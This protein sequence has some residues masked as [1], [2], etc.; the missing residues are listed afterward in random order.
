[1][2]P[3]AEGQPPLHREC[4]WGDLSASRMPLSGLVSCRSGSPCGRRSPTRAGCWPPVCSC[5][6]CPPCGSRWWRWASCSPSAD[7]RRGT[8]RRTDAQSPGAAGP[9]EHGVRVAGRPACATA[10]AA[11]IHA[12]LAPRARG[13]CSRHCRALRTRSRHRPTRMSVHAPLQMAQAHCPP[14]GPCGWWFCMGPSGRPCTE[15]TGKTLVVGGR[16]SG[17]AHPHPTADGQRE[18]GPSARNAAGLGWRPSPT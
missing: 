5:P 18:A 16:G 15:S 7:R 12:R 9:A 8:R 6:S 14:P 4:A 13:H 11:P 1:M 3:G 2:A 10:R 17:K